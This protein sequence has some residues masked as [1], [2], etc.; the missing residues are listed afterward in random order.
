L[1]R[2]GSVPASKV[3]SSLGSFDLSPYWDKK[4][5][6]TVSASARRSPIRA[7]DLERVAKEAWDARPAKSDDEDEASNGCRILLRTEGDLCTLSLDTTGVHLY[8]RGYRQEV[9]RAPLRETLAAGILTLARYD[10]SELLWDPMCGSGTLPIEGALMAMHRAPAVDRDDLAFQRWPSFNRQ[11]YEAKR[12]H[13]RAQRIDTPRAA[14]LGQDIN[15]GSLGTARRN[16]KR[17]GLESVVS[18][19]RAD[20]TARAMPPA[21]RGLLVANLPYGK[22]VGER[23][24]LEALYGGFGDR[25]VSDLRLWRAALLG[26]DRRLIPLLKRRFDEEVP[27]DNGGIPCWLLLSN[28]R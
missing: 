2:L 17:A 20:V 9:S 18:W 10:G 7:T 1:L 27:L 26:A 13:V 11:Q 22:R 14:I 16:A 21:E 24:S 3:R 5:P 4:T 15:A 12:A 19:T 23:Q 6:L 8:R 28:V 25:L